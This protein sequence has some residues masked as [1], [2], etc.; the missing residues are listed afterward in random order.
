MVTLVQIYNVQRTSILQQ[1]CIGHF[2]QLFWLLFW[3]PPLLYL[4]CHFSQ[5][6]P[7]VTFPSWIS[8]FYQRK[9]RGITYAT[10]AKC[11]MQLTHSVQLKVLQSHKA[12][13]KNMLLG[14]GDSHLCNT[15]QYSQICSRTGWETLINKVLKLQLHKLWFYTYWSSNAISSLINSTMVSSRFWTLNFTGTCWYICRFWGVQ[16]EYWNRNNHT[17]ILYVWHYYYITHTFHSSNCTISALWIQ[18]ET[19]FKKKKKLPK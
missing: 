19:N 17:L 18:G 14:Q 9:C 11:Q 3:G 13:T 4:Y 5:L 8:N 1:N 16:P 6:S 15:V 7:S 2:D 12:V 10:G